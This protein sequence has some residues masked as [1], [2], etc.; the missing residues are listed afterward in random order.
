MM[1]QKEEATTGGSEVRLHQAPYLSPF[2][3]SKPQILTIHS[4][5]H[6]YARSGLKLGPSLSGTDTYYANESCYVET[7]R[8]GEAT[9]TPYGSRLTLPACQ[10]AWLHAPGHRWARSQARRNTRPPVSNTISHLEGAADADQPHSRPND[11]A[12]LWLAKTSLC[13]FH[14]INLCYNFVRIIYLCI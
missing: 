2:G 11:C 1:R 9:P 3:R 12:E 6:A 5:P 13:N 14:N 8:R 4:T 7:A 10:P